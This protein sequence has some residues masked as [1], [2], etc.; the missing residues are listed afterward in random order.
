MSQR[1][2][3]LW[4]RT[5]KRLQTASI[6]YKHVF[7]LIL[8]H[9]P[10]FHFTMGQIKANI[11]PQSLE[12]LHFT[13]SPFC[14]F[15]HP[16]NWDAKQGGRNV[17][18]WMQFEKPGDASQDTDARYEKTHVFHPLLLHSAAFTHRERWGRRVHLRSKIALPGALR[19]SL[20]LAFCVFFSIALCCGRGTRGIKSKYVRFPGSVTL[21]TFQHQEAALQSRE[22]NSVSFHS[23]RTFSDWF[24]VTSQQE[25][26]G[27]DLGP[28]P[29]SKHAN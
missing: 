2:V 29:G 27:L 12:F 24:R 13:R 18:M 6:I 23:N 8:F 28:L 10:P 26:S 4:A 25:G 21:N 9:F 15:I 22:W 7:L 20:G 14:F 11:L 17:E 3:N 1:N 16:W 19:G 5:T